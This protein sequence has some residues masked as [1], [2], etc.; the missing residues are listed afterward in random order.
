MRFLHKMI[1][2][3]KRNFLS[4]SLLFA[5]LIF[6]VGL[7]IQRSQA[8]IIIQMNPFSAADQNGLS[9]FWDWQMIET[10]HFRL[11]FPK[12]L[13]TVAKKA[14]NYCE[15]ANQL[16]FPILQWQP[17]YKAQILLIDNQDSANGL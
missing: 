7:P 14:A 3:N 9:P 1:Q 8:A 11:I 6:S 15:E 5:S 16:L 13:E 10:D 12:E 4:A 17:H 2:S